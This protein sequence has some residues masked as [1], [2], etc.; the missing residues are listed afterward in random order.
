LN[1]LESNPP[2]DSF[3]AGYDLEPLPLPS[4]RRLPLLTA[5][6]VVALVAVAAFI[7]GVEVQKRMG[8]GSG[9]SAGGSSFASRFA[10]AGS[11]AAGATGRPT[12]SAGGFAGGGTTFGT[13]SLIKGSTLYVT[14]ASGNT[15]KVTTSGA[16]VSK[17]ASASIKAIRPGQTVVV[18]GSSGRNGE[19]A[20]QSITIG[21][22]GGGFGGGR[23]FGSGGGGGGGGFGS[24]TNG[25]PTGFG[26]GGG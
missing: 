1:A 24:G 5:L 11:S 14:D 20:A 23:G 25:A 4:R 21:G 26:G 12:G 15:V 6:L 22:A 10:R 2:H 8:S 3:D 19:L 18:R 7:G 13:V 17:T 9:S 16:T